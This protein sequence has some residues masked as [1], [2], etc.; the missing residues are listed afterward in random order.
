MAKKRTIVEEIV[1]DSTFET[2][3]KDRPKCIGQKAVYCNEELCG[4]WFT[5]CNNSLIESNT[6]ENKNANILQ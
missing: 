2:D 6:E 5:I 1:I 4:K 3:D